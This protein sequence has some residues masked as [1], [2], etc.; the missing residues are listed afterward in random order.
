MMPTNGATPTGCAHLGPGVMAELAD[1]LLAA[2]SH[3][4]ADGVGACLDDEFVHWLN[5][6]DREQGREGLLATLRLEREH[7]RETS[8][9]VRAEVGTD[10]GFVLQ[11]VAAGTT[12]GGRAY[13]IPVCIVATVSADGERVVRIDEYASSDHVAPLLQELLGT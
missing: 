1:R 7:V 4:D 12:N 9:E 5:L 8:F 13:R 10:D 3:Y 6:T 2:L 11:L